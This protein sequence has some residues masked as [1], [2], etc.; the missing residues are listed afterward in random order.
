MLMVAES[1]Q[2]CLQNKDT[3]PKVKGTRL[4]K[5]WPNGSQ[6]CGSNHAGTVPEARKSRVGSS[7]SQNSIIDGRFVFVRRTV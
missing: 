6:S 7:Q 3:I 2:S 5:V 4:E 1:N